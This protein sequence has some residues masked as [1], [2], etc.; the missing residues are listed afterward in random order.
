[1][2]TLGDKLRAAR[3]ERGISLEDISEETKISLRYLKA[4][5]SSD[6]AGLPGTVFAR[7]FTRQYAHYIGIGA[8]GIKPGELD[9]Q[10][11]LAFPRESE[12]MPQ[13][14][15]STT[16]S[17]PQQPIEIAPLAE[18][19]NWNKIGLSTLGL[20][21][22]LG[23]GAAIFRVW[24]EA[25]SLIES[26]REQAKQQ[27]VQQAQQQ[28]VV[29]PVSQPVAPPDVPQ[30]QIE[31]T[32]APAAAGQPATAETTITISGNGMAVRVVAEQDTWVSMNANGGHVFS[33][34]LKAN[35]SRTIS[36]VENAQL[37]IGNAGGV[38]IATNGKDIGPI[39]L[40]GQVRTVTLTPEGPKIGAGPLL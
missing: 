11:Q 3:T 5:E 8:L 13:L 2:I 19:W 37:V 34:L 20:L 36:G 32:T 25:P 24:Q 40:P 33:E 35:Q 27:Q 17:I 12:A 38:K 14:S 30:V 23:A 26:A 29:T 22:V 9:E 7:N 18:A 21:A 10:I 1:M 6:A 39:G 15:Q 28:Q 16:A 4:I 31:Q